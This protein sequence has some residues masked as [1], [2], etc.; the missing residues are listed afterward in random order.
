MK[1]TAGIGSTDAYIP[2]VEAGAQELFCGYVPADWMEKYGI[3]LPL[4]RRE[5]LYY[6]VQIGAR[7]ELQILGSM[8][9]VYGVPV[10]ITLNSLYYT[11][12]QYP[13]GWE[14][15]NV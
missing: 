4:N 3:F 2:C 10:T 12:E 9:E 15:A 13:A 14:A 7:S 11:P 8:K 6:P 5:V 1:I